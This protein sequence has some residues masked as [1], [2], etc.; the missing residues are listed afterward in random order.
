VSYCASP[1]CIRGIGVDEVLQGIEQRYLGERASL[2][3][4]A[5]EVR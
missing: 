1:V 3:S 4:V 5:P 2:D